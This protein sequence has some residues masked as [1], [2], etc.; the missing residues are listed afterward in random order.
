MIKQMITVGA[1]AAG[2][3]GALLMG[4]LARTPAALTYEPPVPVAGAALVAE[5]PVVVETKAS[6][7]PAPA[8]PA[9]IVTVA[10]RKPTKAVPQETT[11]E[12]CSDWTVVGAKFIERGGATGA[13]AVRT[14]C[15]TPTVR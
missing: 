3:A 14:L 11:L 10:L 9:R 4:H 6:L 15:E 7:A 13:R 1:F 2:G 5:A 8:E 12:P